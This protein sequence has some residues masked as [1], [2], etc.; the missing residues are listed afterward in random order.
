METNRKEPLGIYIHIP[1]CERKCRYCAFLSSSSFSESE[2]SGYAELLCRE[3]GIYGRYCGRQAVDSIFIGG[4]TPSLLSPGDIKMIL[5]AVRGCFDVSG[6]CE[7]TMEANP[8]SLSLE[9]ITAVKDAGISRISM[10]VQSFQPE[11]LKGLGRIHT[12][13]RAVDAFRSLRDSGPDNVNIDLMFAYPGHT[14]DMWMKDLEMI[15][16]LLPDHVS[17]YSLQL[18]EG[19]PFYEE[20]KRGKTD[21]PSDDEEEKMYHRTCRYLGALG[22]VHYEISNWARPGK[23]CRHNLKYWRFRPFIGIG[24]GSSSFAGGRRYK[25]TDSM[26]KYRKAVKEGILPLDGC[27]DAEMPAAVTGA[28]SGCLQSPAEIMPESR[29]TGMGIYCMMALRTACGIDFDEFREMFGVEFETAYGDMK[30]SIEKYA[31]QGLM[32]ENGRRLALT[33]KGIYSSNDIMAEFLR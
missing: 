13:S 12:A 14:E 4:G 18:E 26:E 6:D 30:E 31:G 1:F 22:Y 23:E 33:E 16:R 32:K 25:N 15:G 2:R 10:G 19:T 27:V 11:C 21:L 3:I 20:Y 24:L 5:D 8:E 29:E 7:I 28:G 17:C 9:K